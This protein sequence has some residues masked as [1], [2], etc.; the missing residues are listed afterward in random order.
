MSM[1]KAVQDVRKLEIRLIF[2]NKYLTINVLE[3]FLADLNSSRFLK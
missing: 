2:F 3:Y 1:N